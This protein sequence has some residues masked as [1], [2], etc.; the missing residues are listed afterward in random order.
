MFV[1]LPSMFD[2][3][4]LFGLRSSSRLRDG[5][6]ALKRCLMMGNCL[7]ES[8]YYMSLILRKKQYTG[9]S[10]WLSIATAS[11]LLSPI[12]A[13]GETTY[14]MEGE[15]RASVIVEKADHVRFPKEA[16]EVNV[17]IS[18]NGEGGA[19]DVRKYRVMSKGSENTIV[20]VTE[21]ASDRGQIML[22]KGRDL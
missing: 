7:C 6:H 4:S 19:P 15:V 13:T 18:T 8:S 5:R 12:W 1:I 14:Q 16:F 17:S 22:T 21:P 20:M 9:Q 11:I 3:V 10:V 2:S